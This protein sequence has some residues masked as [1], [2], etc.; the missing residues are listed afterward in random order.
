MRLLIVTAVH[1][2]IMY[3]FLLLKAEPLF[4]KVAHIRGGKAALP[5]VVLIT[6][7]DNGQHV[8]TGSL[9]SKSLVLTTASCL[10]VPLK[11][12]VVVTG[13]AD[14]GSTRRGVFGLSW[15]I[16]YGDWE[17]I[18]NKP[19]FDKNSDDIA[20]IK[21]SWVNALVKHGKIDYF[22]GS[23]KPGSKLQMVGWGP[24]IDAER[25]LE[26]PERPR[27]ATIRVWDRDHCMNHIKFILPTS[28]PYILPSRL[29]CTDSL[30]IAVNGD[31]GGPVLNKERNI[32]AVLIPR[33]PVPGACFTTS[34]QPNLLIHLRDFRAFLDEYI[35]DDALNRLEPLSL[36]KTKMMTNEVPSV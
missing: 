14:P 15:K 30:A 9:I 13:S 7:K 24:T 17:R 16:T 11:D 10:N 18:N 21:L 20:L 6:R 8:C 23:D 4:G 2:W 1:F 5:F 33:C 36:V 34:A 28:T 19:K 22:D 3:Q 26:R 12:L 32:V 35:N 25:L 27:A 31:F 29:M